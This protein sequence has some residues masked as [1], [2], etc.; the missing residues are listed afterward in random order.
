MK[1]SPRVL[2]AIALS[3]FALC[4]TWG[5]DKCLSPA[6]HDPGRTNGKQMVLKDQAMSQ[7][8]DMTGPSVY[9]Y[10]NG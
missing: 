4:F 9:F 6:S 5:Q 3:S 10:F 8:S 2:E 1:E 7:V